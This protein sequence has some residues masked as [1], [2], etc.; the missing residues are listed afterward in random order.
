MLQYANKVYK[1]HDVEREREREKEKEK[2]GGQAAEEMLQTRDEVLHIHL[3]EA[4]T[5]GEREVW[6]VGS[7]QGARHRCP[8]ATRG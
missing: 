3:R 7:V 6:G 5:K 4:A 1:G 8:H 2:D